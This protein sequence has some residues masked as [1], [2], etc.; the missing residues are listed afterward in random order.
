MAKDLP[1]ASRSGYIPTLD[2]WRAIAVLG[3]IAFHASVVRLGPLSDA[4]LHS[5]GFLGVDLFF[6]ISGLLIC[7]R[8]L[9][10]EQIHGHISL[11]DFYIRR[12]CRI[13]PPAFLFLVVLGILGLTHVV[14]VDPRSWLCSALFVNNYYFAHL[15]ASYYFGHLQ[16]P[17]QG[18]YTNHF[19][20]LAVEEHFYLLLPGILYFFP[21]RRVRILTI[22]IL[23]FLALSILVRAH[24]TWMI[25]LGG[26]AAYARTELRINALLFPA[27]MAIL[28][29][30]PRFRAFCTNWSTPLF[31]ILF[32]GFVMVMGLKLGIVPDDWLVLPVALPFLVAGTSLQPASDLSRILEVAPLRFLGRISYSLYLWQQLFFIGSSLPYRAA[33][34]L[35]HL[36]GGPW[37]IAAILLVA[38]GSYFL[39]E[40]PFIRLGHRLAPPATPG[41]RDLDAGTTAVLVADQA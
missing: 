34:P 19:W 12:F 36:Q 10:E 5:L 28:L 15:H 30:G 24:P 32:F 6:A 33:G 13:L 40:K 2:G 35:A 22:L 16:D 3:V 1:N 27:L 4:W 31:I 25:A 29:R 11:K 21:R 14:R 9:E 39:I 23:F 8:L 17:D 37:N 7:S 26:N 38:S 20:S 41:H 18:F